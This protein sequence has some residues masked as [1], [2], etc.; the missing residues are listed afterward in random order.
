[1][2]QGWKIV[3]HFK[4]A[5]GVTKAVRPQTPVNDG[6]W[7]PVVCERTA[8][9]VAMTIEGVRHSSI[10]VLTTVTNGAS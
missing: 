2:A 1:M 8:T 4:D 10:G 7:H 5:L 3:C 9:G 6:A